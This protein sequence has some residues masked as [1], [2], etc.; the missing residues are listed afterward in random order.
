MYENRRGRRQSNLF[1]LFISDFNLR[2]SSLRTVDEC[3]STYRFGHEHRQVANIRYLLGETVVYRVLS[4]VAT[5]RE[6]HK[7]PVK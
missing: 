3:L 7:M 5:L 6:K 4:I 2:D 1:S